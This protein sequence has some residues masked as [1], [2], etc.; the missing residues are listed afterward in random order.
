ML[1]NNFSKIQPIIP[2]RKQY[3]PGVHKNTYVLHSV[4]ACYVF[5]FKC[6]NSDNQSYCVFIDIEFTHYVWHRCNFKYKFIDFHNESFDLIWVNFYTP[7]ASFAVPDIGD[8]CSRSMSV[9]CHI[10]VSITLADQK[11]RWWE[12]IMIVRWSPQ[13]KQWNKQSYIEEKQPQAHWRYH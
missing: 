7:S 3:V 5:P 13:G 9:W 10:F 2:V 6:S 1:Q 12:T 11:H 8:V 4:V